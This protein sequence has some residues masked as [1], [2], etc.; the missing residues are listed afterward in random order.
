MGQ[1]VSGMVCSKSNL[2][3]VNVAPVSAFLHVMVITPSPARQGRRPPVRARTRARPPRARPAG[4]ARELQQTA[5]RNGAME[6]VTARPPAGG[7]SRQRIT[8]IG[9]NRGAKGVLRAGSRATV[10]V[11]MEIGNGTKPDYLTISKWGAISNVR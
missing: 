10:V 1:L 3:W 5:G 8:E 4:T 6:L 9:R 11:Y 2:M 7:D